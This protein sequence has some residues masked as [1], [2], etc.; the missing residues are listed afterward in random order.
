MLSFRLGLDEV[1][2][3][4]DTKGVGISI[5]VAHGSRPRSSQR[6]GTTPPNALDA[7]DA[8]VDIGLSGC[9]RHGVWHAAGVVGQVPM[10]G[11][12]NVVCPTTMA[13]SFGRVRFG[14]GK[15]LRDWKPT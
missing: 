4:G 6:G 9:R 2:E 10:L 13:T 11:E 15:D 14:R 1:V 8:P 12:A 5:I 7:V 3:V